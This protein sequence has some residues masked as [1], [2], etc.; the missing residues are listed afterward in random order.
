MK[1]GGLRTIGPSTVRVP[2]GTCRRAAGNC[3]PPS[4]LYMPQS[5]RGFPSTASRLFY[6]KLVPSVRTSCRFWTL[7]ASQI[8]GAVGLAIR[9]ILTWCGQAP[10]EVRTCPLRQLQETAGGASVSIV[11]V[12]C[13]ASDPR[14]CDRRHKLPSSTPSFFGRRVTPG[15]LL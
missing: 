13:L 9:S 12:A 1:V 3:H 7:F 2:G 5:R 8:A 11:C 4:R 15:A 6:F 10:S 14:R